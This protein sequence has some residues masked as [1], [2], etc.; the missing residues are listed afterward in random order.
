PLA[1]VIGVAPCNRDRGTRRGRR[2]VYG[3]RADVRPVLSMGA[4][5]ATRH[6]PVIT[7]LDDRRLAAGKAEQVA[8]A[9]CLHTLL[10][11]MNARVRVCPRTRCIAVSNVGAIF[12]TPSAQMTRL[13]A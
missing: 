1:A 7:A 6:D 5:V 13:A 10:T 2:P 12:C 3:G 9:A 8:V 11:I 4:R